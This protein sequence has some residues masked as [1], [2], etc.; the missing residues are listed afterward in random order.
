MTAVWASHHEAL[1]SDGVVAPHGFA[2]LMGADLGVCLIGATYRGQQWTPA[3]RLPHW[4]DELST[5][6]KRCYGR[7]S[8]PPCVAIGTAN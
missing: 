1:C 2:P 7:S 8:G 5:L 4:R 3:L 6:L